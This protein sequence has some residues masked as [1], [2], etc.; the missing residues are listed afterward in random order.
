MFLQLDRHIYKGIV[1]SVKFSPFCSCSEQ[2]FAAAGTLTDCVMSLRSHWYSSNTGA[3]L[4]AER[5]WA[6]AVGGRSQV[7]AGGFIKTR[8]SIDLCTDALG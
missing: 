2:A 4:T 3:I 5:K 8:R 6:T 7:R 1:L